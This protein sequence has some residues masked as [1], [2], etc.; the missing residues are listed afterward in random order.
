VRL[1]A[2]LVDRLFHASSDTA[3]AALLVDYFARAPDPD[4]GTAIALLLD[5]AAFP[6]LSPAMMR[7]L[8]A[9][10][11]DPALFEMSHAF[12]GDLAET[13]ALL[14][15]ARISNRQT[16]ALHDVL[17]TLNVASGAD[18]VETIE[19]WLDTLEATERWVLLKLAGR[20]LNAGVSPQLIRS[21]LA[22]LGGVPVGRV[23]EIWHAQTPPFTRLFDWLEGRAGQP[24]SLGGLAFAPVMRTSPAGPALLHRLDPSEFAAEWMCAG[25]RVQ[26][27]AAGARRMVFAANGDDVSGDHTE[28]LGAV[29][30]A[31]VLDGVVTEPGGVLRVFDLLAEA[32]EDL[33]DRPLSE[34]RVRLET[35]VA[36][37]AAPVIRLHPWLRFRG[38]EDLRALHG[39]CR[40]SGAK[41]LVLK[42]RDRGY[43]AGSR[44][45]DWYSWRRDPLIAK[46]V[47]MYLQRPD[48][49]ASGPEATFGAWRNGSGS[50]ELVPIARA[51]LDPSAADLGGL[52]TWIRDHL[53]KRYGPV[54]EVAPELVMELAFD[55]VEPAARRKAGLVLTEARVTA[56]DW[57]ASAKKAEGLADLESLVG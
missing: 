9:E 27:C 50:Q 46:A 47:L 13:T 54:T 48:G 31:A 17:D 43:T 32:G 35:L 5:L 44:G 4:R 55:A 10:R 37:G 36:G 28:I 53:V 2:D 19:P 30:F 39:N 40:C 21:S 42:R 38:A 14:W 20:R 29:N 49:G 6:R 57:G 51:P 8:G 1:F 11:L 25:R 34:R 56:I 52:D 33:R 18:L 3:K 7:R 41:G 26:V 15:P 45:D 24:S 16:P 12:V 22:A 23:E